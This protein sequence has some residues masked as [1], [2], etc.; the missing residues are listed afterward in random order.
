MGGS[1]G[2]PLVEYLDDRLEPTE[3]APM[4][5]FYIYAPTIHC[6]TVLL[7]TEDEPT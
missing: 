1:N 5:L 6:H 4:R 3:D 7:T 2:T